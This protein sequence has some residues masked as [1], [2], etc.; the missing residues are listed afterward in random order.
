MKRYMWLG[1]LVVVLIVAAVLLFPRHQAIPDG[2]SAKVAVILNLSGDAARFDAIKRQTIEVATARIRELYPQLRLDVQMLDAGGGPEAT[3]VA[4]RRGLDAGAR[5]F[6]SG[7]SPTALAI[8]SIVRGQDIPIAQMANA[9][10]PDFGPPRKG[11]Y[12]LWPDWTQEADLIYQLLTDLKIQSVL[13]IHSADPYSGALKATL[14]GLIGNSGS[15]SVQRQQYDPAATPDFRPALLRAK[16][17][18]AQALVIFG[19]PPGIKALMSQ[20]SEVGWDKPLIGGV[21][22]N[23]VS[24]DYVS[25]GLK[26]GLW[27]IETEAMQDTLRAGSEA[28]AFRAQ[29]ER[30]FGQT[31][32]FHALYLA[33]GLYFIATSF[34]DSIPRQD[35][36]LERLE[37]THSFEGASGNVT[38][39]TDGVLRYT[40]RVRKA[41]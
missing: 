35:D 9:A 16:A 6:L 37:A 29:Y 20:M 34:G 40:M 17:D 18:A 32:P 21:N 4:V 31:P 24:A 11:E 7:T 5:Y 36:N 13:V 28:Q 27:V 10:N 1:L 26:G 23:L 3:K 2:E 39:G 25:A 22:I 30:T 14:E 15:I 33:D 38:V 8:A 41:Y 12:R 19:L